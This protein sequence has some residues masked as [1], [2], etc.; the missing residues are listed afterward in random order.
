[1]RTLAPEIGDENLRFVGS[2]GARTEA[3][4]IR[5]SC[6]FPKEIRDVGNP[7]AFPLTQVDAAVDVRG[8][9]HGQRSSKFADIDKV[10]DRT[11]RCTVCRFTPQQG[12]R[13]GRHQATF[14]F[15]CPVREE[16]ARPCVPDIQ[17]S[18]ASQQFKLGTTVTSRRQCI[19][20][21]LDFAARLQAVS[22]VLGTRSGD[23]QTDA[24]FCSKGVAQRTAAFE[25]I[26][27]VWS[28]P[29]PV[30][31]GVPGEMYQI[32]RSDICD[33]APTLIRIAKVRGMPR[34]PF[35]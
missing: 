3:D 30:L 27:I 16:N 12:T 2:I 17:F 10:P 9:K 26:V 4:E 14:T 32:L 1:M 15:A 28:L 35:R 24:A 29:E 25:P 34:Q 22:R 33:Q 6:E 21:I 23:N 20:F 31:F 13:N 19:A 18:Q 11:S 5:S 8:N 7:C